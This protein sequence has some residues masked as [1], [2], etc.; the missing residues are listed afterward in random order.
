MNKVVDILRQIWMNEIQVDIY[1]ICLKFHAI[2]IWTMAKNLNKPRSTL[3]WIVHEM[4]H[5]GWLVE[6]IIKNGFSYS[7]VWPEQIAINIEN[8]QKKLA[9]IWLNLQV[10]KNLFDEQTSPNKYKPKMRFYENLEAI[11]FIQ[12]TSSNFHEWYFIRNIDAIKQSLNRDLD[13]IIKNF[14]TTKETIQKSIMLD[15]PLAHE[16]KKTLRK[17]NKDNHQIKF[18][19]KR[20]KPFLS[21]NLLMDWVY[22]HICYDEYPIA[23][24]INNSVF[25]ETQKMIF[26]TIRETIS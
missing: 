17:L 2:S 25:Y 15:T 8:E 21:D 6:N 10:Y 19:P 3:Y 12:S 11:K 9:N 24:E 23:I 14:L 22:Y 18:L 5:K 1:L 16:Y 13:T 26:D 7:V 20:T 4:I